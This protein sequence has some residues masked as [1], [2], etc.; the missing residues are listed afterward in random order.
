[1]K[2]TAV[3]PYCPV[4]EWRRLLFDFTVD[5]LERN[6]LDVEVGHSDNRGNPAT[7]NHPEAI[8]RAAERAQ[9]DV[10]VIV[11]ADS[12]PTG[13]WR[14]AIEDV[15]EG[16]ASW[17]LLYYYV[18]LNEEWT[19]SVISDPDD[20]VV[21]PVEEASTEWTGYQVSW[22]GFQVVRQ[23]DFWRVGGWDERFKGW[24]SDD[25]CFGLA[26]DTMVGSHTRYPG[27][28][29]HLWH[30]QTPETSFLHAAWDDQFTLTE[31]Y[32]AAAGNPELMAEVMRR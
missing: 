10:L 13:D 7:F 18:K 17:A 4:D 28:V 5:Y 16:K 26:M 30:P 8:N 1:M 31:R 20:A 23:E 11:D 22:A 15:G 27:S 3:V 19:R 25:V 9:H 6:G 2:A 32:M 21:V 29:V 12:V 24:G 14:Q